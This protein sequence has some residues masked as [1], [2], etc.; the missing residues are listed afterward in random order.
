MNYP[1]RMTGHVAIEDKNDLDKLVK[2][3]GTNPKNGFA[4]LGYEHGD[5]IASDLMN[6]FTVFTTIPTDKIVHMPN[7]KGID[8]HNGK[9]EINID[10]KKQVM[11]DLPLHL[12]IKKQDVSIDTI[13]NT[14]KKIKDEESV[15][16]YGIEYD[17]LKA[18][19]KK[20][21]KYD[22]ENIARLWGMMYEYAGSLCQVG[23]KRTEQETRM[24]MLESDIE[25]ATPV[26]GDEETVKSVK[27]AK[28]S[29]LD[30]IAGVINDEQKQ[31]RGASGEVIGTLNP[32]AIPNVSTFT[33]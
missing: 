11:R 19:E 33:T 15:K 30:S 28:E 22:E 3:L 7:V 25:T 16:T 31:S 23:S 21:L 13:E 1:I 9:Y 27:H 6:T 18:D 10:D 8:I 17:E 5:K 29:L 14:M 2:I 4:P 20:K 26:L 32:Y 12:W 24:R